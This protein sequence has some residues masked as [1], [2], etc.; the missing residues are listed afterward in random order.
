MHFSFASI[1]RHLFAAGCAVALAAAMFAQSVGSPADEDEHTRLV[2]EYMAKRAAWVAL[3]AQEY[4][5]AKKAKDPKTKEAILRK[6]DADVQKL[7]NDAAEL[8]ARVKASGEAKKNK[9]G[10]GRN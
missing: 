3:R 4:E 1:L 9:N 6:L 10:K 7:R 8:A 2:Q 5:K